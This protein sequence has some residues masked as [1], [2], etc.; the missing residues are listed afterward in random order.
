MLWRVSV[1]KR[2][3]TL[4]RSAGL[5]FSPQE[6]NKTQCTVEATG[7]KLTLRAPPC[8][9]GISPHRNS[10]LMCNHIVQIS[11]RPLQLPA[12]DSLGCLSSVFK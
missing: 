1:N 12:I 4:L 3:R 8:A 2:C 7:R 6:K 9:P 11:K 10:F 5:I